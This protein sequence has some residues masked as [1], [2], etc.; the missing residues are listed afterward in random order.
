MCLKKLQTERGTIYGA[1][2]AINLSIP[3]NVENVIMIKQIT[4]KFNTVWQNAT[5]INTFD[6][7][8]RVVFI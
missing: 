4:F 5:R 8:I 2:A 7:A 1:G 3:P 6:E